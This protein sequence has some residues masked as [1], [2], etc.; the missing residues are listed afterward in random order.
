MNTN[1][2]RVFIRALFLVF[3]LIPL[4]LS[5]APTVLT[6]SNRDTK[7]LTPCA[8]HLRV[9]SGTVPTTPTLLT[10]PQLGMVP[11]NCP[12]GPTPQPIFSDIGPVVGAAPLWVTGFGGPHAVINIP[13]YFTYTQYGW[14]W[15]LL[16]KMQSGYMHPITLEGGNLLNG[17]LLW[18]QIGQQNPSTSPVLDPLHSGQQP[19]AGSGLNWPSYVYIPTAGCYYLEAK[20]PGGHWRIIFAAGR[21]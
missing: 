12:P 14:T 10:P 6:A 5:C 21:Q 13:T 7:G 3:T 20:W 11:Q 15:K 4:L 19:S 18:F 8:N 9:P 1:A 17:T 16:W 2:V